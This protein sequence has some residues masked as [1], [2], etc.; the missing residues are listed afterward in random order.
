MGIFCAEDELDKANQQQT[1]AQH[2]ED[3]E[4][5]AEI[6]FAEP[7]LERHM[8]VLVNARKKTP[9]PPVVFYT[10]FS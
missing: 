8:L 6:K 2:E 5:V 7:T 3:E 9:R 10:L 1:T 4:E